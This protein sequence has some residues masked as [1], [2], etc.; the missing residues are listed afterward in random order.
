MAS[1]TVK[2]IFDCEKSGEKRIAQ[3]NIKA[4]EIIKDAKNRATEAAAAIIAD[5]KEKAD[6]IEDTALKE[7]DAILNKTET[8]ENDDIFKVDP[9]KYKKAVKAVRSRALK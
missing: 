4:K 8:V 7:A 1:D 3:A 5:A 6:K 2:A 9:E